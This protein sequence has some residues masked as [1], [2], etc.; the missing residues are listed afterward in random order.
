MIGIS[1]IICTYNGGV[2]LEK[3]IAHIALQKGVSLP[4][5][6]I[7]VDNN[8]T[9]NTSKIAK[10]LFLKYNI[11]NYQIVFESKPG[12]LFARIKGAII[13]KYDTLVYCDDDNWLEEN[14]LCN[15]KAGF[16][17]YPEAG[18][19]GAWSTPVFD[20]GQIVPN[21]FN[22]VQES[23]AIGGKPQNDREH[24]AV[25]GA[26]LAIKKTITDQIFKEPFLFQSRTGTQLLSGE[27]DEICYKT[28]ALGFKV[29]KLKAL[30][31]THYIAANKLTW[32][33]I[34]RLYMGFGYGDMLLSCQ[35]YRKSKTRL[36]LG[37]FIHNLLK[38]VRNPKAFWH[39]LRDI[40]GEVDSLLFYRIQGS[41]NYIKDFKS[42]S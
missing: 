10:D 1:I 34:S 23:L 40:E 20:D 5:E 16:D 31:F 24:Y 15:V 17:K 4:F 36:F 29:Y 26:G 41:F 21:W 6:V 18:I 3:T 33:Y 12:V 37:Y 11:A 14:Y 30:Q 7:L 28:R 35:K 32:S 22:S 8:S 2:R 19:L 42:I 25:W 9:D 39:W 27:D 13:A 38:I